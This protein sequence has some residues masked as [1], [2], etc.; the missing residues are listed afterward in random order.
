MSGDQLVVKYDSVL[1][2]LRLRGFSEKDLDVLFAICAYMRDREGDVVTLTYDVL[3]KAAGWDR[4]QRAELFHK[5]LKGIV[6]KL[7][8]VG[9]TIDVSETD[10]ISFNLFSTFEGS[11]KKRVLSVQVNQRYRYILNRLTER[12]TRFEL[13][14]YVALDGRYAKLL[15]KQLRQRYKLRGHFWQPT[16]EE[17]R[18]ALDIP[19]SCPTFKLSHKIAPAIEEVKKVKD[20][21]DLG[22]EVIRSDRRGRAVT[23]FRFTWTT[24]DHLQ[25]QMDLTDWERAHPK[26]QEEAAEEPRVPKRRRG[27]PKKERP[28]AFEERQRTAADFEEL[29]KR[30]RKN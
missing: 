14:E 5:E 25:G 12:F 22:M 4:S 27:R 21:K 26:G 10:F 29:E 16:V 3:M 8:Q 20:F 9:D 13:K 30:L 19:D 2:R 24:K 6:E 11:A 7:R 15:Y 28:D 1:D 23:G 17:L 18:T